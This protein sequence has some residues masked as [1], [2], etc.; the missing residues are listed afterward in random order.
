MKKTE[1][2]LF[3]ESELPLISQLQLTNW[4]KPCIVLLEGQMGAGKTTL[5]KQLCK[6]LG[7]NEGVS[8]PT[9]SIVNEYKGNPFTIFHFDLYRLKSED[10]LF[11]LGFE[12]YLYQHAYLFIEWPQ[13]ALNFLPMD[14]IHLQLNVVA[15]QRELIVTYK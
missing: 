4:P 10:E 15:Q 12:D 1:S 7:V 6:D 2:Y 5:V 3:S 14:V 8:S 11:D 13:L 9:Y